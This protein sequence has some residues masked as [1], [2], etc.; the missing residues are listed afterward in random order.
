EQ[1][2]RLEIFPGTS[3]ATKT[4]TVMSGV[5]TVQASRYGQPVFGYAT[6]ERAS[7]ALDNDLHTAWKVGGANGKIVGEKIQV[8]LD[9]PIT[10]DHVNL[11]QPIYGPRGRWISEAKLSF[12][13]GNSVDRPLLPAS[14]D[15]AGGGQT[16]RFPR[17][18]FRTF[19]IT[20]QKL[21]TFQG[22]RAVGLDK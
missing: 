21:A 13:G 5:K 9:H 19:T 10:T 6:E 11:V 3:D 18:T 20:I 15:E 8:V 16:V 17:R 7:Q 2:Q 4:V 22:K 1:D 14:R 12:D